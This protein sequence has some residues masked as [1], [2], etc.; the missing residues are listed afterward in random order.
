[1]NLGRLPFVWWQLPLATKWSSTT[2]YLVKGNSQHLTIFGH[3]IPPNIG[4]GI[5][6][7]SKEREYYVIIS[8]KYLTYSDGPVVHQNQLNNS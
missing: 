5:L 1:M 3:G 2:P 6:P 8:N 7:L 4:Q